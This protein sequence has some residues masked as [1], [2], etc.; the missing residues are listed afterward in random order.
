MN[1]S[2]LGTEAKNSVVLDSACSSTV[3][4]K[5]W[6]KTYIDSLCKTKDR[7]HIEFSESN[8]IVQFDGEILFFQVSCILPESLAG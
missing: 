1:I 7:E 5:E 8:K 2:Q 3:C 6:L 4:G